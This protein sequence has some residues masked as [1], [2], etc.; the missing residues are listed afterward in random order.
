LALGSVLV[1]D[2]EFIIADEPTS[3]LDENQSYL[4][5][6]KLYDLSKNGVTILLITHDLTMAKAYSNRLIALHKHR[7]QLDISINDLDLHRQ[8]LKNIGLDFEDKLFHSRKEQL[9]GSTKV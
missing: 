4:I 9:D 7:I 2:P 3:G 5:M 1:S 8:E 6:D